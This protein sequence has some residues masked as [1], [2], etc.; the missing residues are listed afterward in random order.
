MKKSSYYAH[1]QFRQVK[2]IATNAPETFRENPIS[3]LK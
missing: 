3:N 2:S 1:I